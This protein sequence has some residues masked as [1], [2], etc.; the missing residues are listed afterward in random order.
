M[1]GG[2]PT[3]YG[4]VDNPNDEIDTLGLIFLLGG[5]TPSG[6]PR[7]SSSWLARYGPASIRK[8]HLIPQVMLK[9]ADFMSTLNVLL[10]VTE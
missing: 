7:N 6:I 9:N 5:T 10:K 3:L 2:N 4:Y 1:A 8:H